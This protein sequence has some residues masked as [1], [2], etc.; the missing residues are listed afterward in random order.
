MMSHAIK[1]RTGRH[2]RSTIRGT[3]CK[4][5]NELG[6]TLRYVTAEMARDKWSVNVLT[7]V[8]A[9]KGRGLCGNRGSV[10]V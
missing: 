7:D 9:T 8:G 2:A 3:G 6:R 1:T 5:G 10:G 4:G